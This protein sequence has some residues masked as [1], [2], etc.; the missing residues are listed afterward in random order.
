MTQYAIIIM[1]GAADEPQERLGG[2]TPLEK[3]NIP[4]TDWIS[5][6]GRLGMVQT[7]PEGFTPGSDVAQMSLLGY[8]P[9]TCYTGRAP[10]EA[11][12]RGINA[13][14]SDWIFRCNLVTIADG[15]MEDYSAGHIDSVQAGQLIQD[16]DKKLG[17][18]AVR[19]YPGVSYR[20]LM[21]HTG[22]PFDMETYPPHDIMGKPI[23]KHLPRGKG[24]KELCRLMQEAEQILQGHEINKIR[25]DLGENPANAI[26]L[27]GQGHRPQLDT[28]HRRFGLTGAVITGVD[29][30]RGIGKLTGMDL[31]EVKGATGYLDTNY[32][33]KGQAAIAA[34]A[35][36]DLVVVHIEAPDEAGHG[37]LLDEKVQSIEQIDQ[38]VVGPLLDYFRKQT[39]NW[40]IMV[41]PDHPTPV[42]V[43]TH[44][45]EPVPF[46]QAGTGVA[47][48]LQ[49]PF[50][51]SNAK[52]SGLHINPGCD[53][54]EYFLKG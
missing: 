25:Q 30:M 27:W 1:D 15:I 24:G 26:W 51:E 13:Q 28:F 47:S 35:D 20:H 21:V 12:A 8:D 31:I 17:S 16:I 46:A 5:R 39:A 11:A 6:N 14:P 45:A 34:L 52:N 18:D 23:E 19:F 44:T 4:H 53:L 33:G 54:M 40:R 2:K 36:H 48:T 7:V 50:T 38:H 43:R 41:L 37:A 10:L 49:L 42:R 32:A 29:L 3:A 9:K 22:G